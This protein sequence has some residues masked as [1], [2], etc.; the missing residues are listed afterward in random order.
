MVY[1]IYMVVCLVTGERYVGR[2]TNTHLS[3]RMSQHNYESKRHLREN[4]LHYSIREHGFEN[5]IYGVIEETTD[6]TREDYW[7]EYYQCELNTKVGDQRLDKL[8][9]ILVEKRRGTYEL[10]FKS[11]EIIEVTNL[12]EWCRDTGINLYGLYSIGKNGRTHSQ[13]VVRCER[14]DK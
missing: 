7:T 12:S 3:K 10:E 11:G 2:T 9:N 6:K 13:G 8:T 4:K 1:K 14:V 5:H